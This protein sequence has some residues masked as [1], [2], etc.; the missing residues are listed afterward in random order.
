VT[1]VRSSPTEFFY[2]AHVEACEL[3]RYLLVEFRLVQENAIGVGR[4]RESRRNG[5]AFRCKFAK[6][7][8]QRSVLSANTGDIGQTDFGEPANILVHS[9]TWVRP[10]YRRSP[11][12]ALRT[13]R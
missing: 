13:L 12:G 3:R 7:F 9:A 2:I 5:D 8:A 11:T 4:D 10:D 1:N 6:K